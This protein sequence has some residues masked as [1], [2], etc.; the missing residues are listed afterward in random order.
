LGGIP[1]HA[2]PRLRKPSSSPSVPPPTTRPP[3]SRAVGVG[4][5][6]GAGG[7]G[8]RATEQFLV[9]GTAAGLKY[10]PTAADAAYVRVY[11]LADGGRRLELLHKTQVMLECAFQRVRSSVCPSCACACCCVRAELRGVRVGR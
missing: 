2:A 4:E 5:L 10:V 7:S 3:T 8:G 11:R 1:L 9:V 6:A